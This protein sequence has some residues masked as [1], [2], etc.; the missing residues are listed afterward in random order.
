LSE[1][2][3]GDRPASRRVECNRHKWRRDEGGY[4]VGVRRRGAPSRGPS[5]AVADS[6]DEAKAAF[7]RVWDAHGQ[8]RAEKL[9][10]F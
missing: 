9:D 1:T 4:Q 2:A 7:R 3:P 8:Q 10:Y 5:G 6:L